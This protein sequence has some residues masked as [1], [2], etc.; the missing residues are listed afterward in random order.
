MS[1]PTLITLLSLAIL[2]VGVWL[3]RAAR[4]FGTR[5]ECWYASG[6]IAFA[7]IGCAIGHWIAQI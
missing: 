1:I 7:L 6:L 5:G 2:I 4:V 3:L